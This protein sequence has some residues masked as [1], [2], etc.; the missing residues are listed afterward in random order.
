MS[1]PRLL[2]SSIPFLL[3][4]PSL[5][6]KVQL[7]PKRTFSLILW[8]VKTN[9]PTL[10]ISLPVHK[11]YLLYISSVGLLDYSIT[12]H[13]CSTAPL[14]TP[15]HPGCLLDHSCFQPM[16]VISSQQLQCPY[17]TLQHPF[18]LS[19]TFSARGLIFFS[20][21]PLVPFQVSSWIFSE[22]ETFCALE[23][24]VCFCSDLPCLSDSFPEPLSLH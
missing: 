21:S 9:P 24:K 18:Q 23:S 16:V 17:R 1:C 20:S 11:T 22:T 2:S 19:A 3:F 12:T 14:L 15:A 13:C 8:P 10:K 4:W 6:T 7:S 5:H